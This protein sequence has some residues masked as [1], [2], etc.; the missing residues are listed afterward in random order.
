MRMSYKSNK[1]NGSNQFQEHSG[2]QRERV[3]VIQNYM[4][5]Y[6][7]GLTGG[8]L[9][10]GSMLTG[11]A[12]AQS[13]MGPVP[14]PADGSLTM[15]GITLYGIVDIGL[16]YETPRCALQR[17]LSRPAAPTSCRRTAISSAGRHPEQPEP[18]QIGLQGIEALGVGDWNAVF[19]LETYFNPQ[20][21]D[22][23]DA[24]KSLAQNNGRAAGQRPTTNLDSSIA[25]QM[26]QQSFV[27]TQ[28]E[29]LRFDHVRST[30]HVYWPMASPSMTPRAPRRRSR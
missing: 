9:L 8:A 15:H 1:T 30:E 2:D 23:S 12:Q 26:F 13:A 22:I 3:C 11:V 28:F 29:D 7:A 19:K 20:S 4:P 16:Q 14:Q 17:L 24:L 27:G 10:L 21:G 6:G 18:V 5:G 25:G